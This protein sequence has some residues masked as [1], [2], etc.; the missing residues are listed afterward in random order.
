[1][2][3]DGKTALYGV[4]GNPVSHSLSPV[5]QNVGFRLLGLNAVYLPFALPV[6][7]FEKSFEGL[8]FIENF[9]GCN[10]T[11]PFK[12]RVLKFA[13]W[14]SPEVETIGSAN[15]V[16]KTED[17]KVELYNTDWVGFIKHLKELTE[18]RGKRVLVL[19]A[20]GTARAVVFALKREGAEVYLWNRTS[21]KAEKLAKLFSAKVVKTPDPSG[22]D[23]IVNT[24]S[25]GL[26]KGAPPLF[27]Y[28]K[29]QPHQVVYDVIYGETPLVA[30]AK[31]RG[32]KAANGLKM[33]LYQ[34][35]ESF[36]IWT[37]LN[38]PRD[39]M[40]EALKRAFNREA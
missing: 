24:T 25:V 19:G 22:F 17:G 5:F 12:E 9:K 21:S 34:G 38:P 33:L 40:W 27:D 16:K 7:D 30:E 10:V 37:G 13:D 1:M 39:E 8:L 32:A 28:S 3:I 36:K 18:V 23:V 6:E 15:T 14:V 31:R 29:I 20:G 2:G 26:K 4:V 35:V 11:V